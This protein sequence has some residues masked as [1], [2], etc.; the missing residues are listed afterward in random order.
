MAFVDDD[1]EDPTG[2]A[3][4]YNVTKSVGFG[5][6]NEREDTLMVQFFLKRIYQTS[7]MKQFTPKGNLTVDGKVGPVTRNWILK[8]QLDM[9]NGGHYCLADG[10]MDKAGNSENSDNHI[11]S[12][13]KTIYTIRLLNNGLRHLDSDVYKTL[14]TNPEV[15]AE[16]RAAF[17][18]MNLAM[19]LGV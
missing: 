5:C 4:F 19:P 6:P 13:S 17:M 10:K 7:A 18:Q 8:F 16:L 9:R 11:A 2:N 1:S 12:M 3:R 15:P 14:P